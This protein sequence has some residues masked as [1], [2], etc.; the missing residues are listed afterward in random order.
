V[1]ESGRHRA[2]RRESLAVLLDRGEPGQHRAH[3]THDAAVHGGG[4]ERQL[5]EAGR[6]DQRQAA[7]HLGAHAHAGRAVGERR[8][9]AD[10]GRR[11]LMAERLLAPVVDEHGPRRSLEQ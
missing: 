1:R 3:L 10:P 7:V 4:R 11:A 6:R 5:G 2:Q 8:D 9:G